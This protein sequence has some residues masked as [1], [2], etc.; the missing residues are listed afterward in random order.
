MA[1]DA[2][3]ADAVG[4]PLAMEGAQGEDT[5]GQTT[6]VD[7]VIPDVERNEGI[8]GKTLHD[9]DVGIS[10]GGK[11]EGA[12]VEREEYIR[13]CGGSIRGCGGARV[14]GCEITIVSFITFLVPPH[15]RTFVPP[16]SV[17]SITVPPIIRTH[18]RGLM[19]EEAEEVVDAL[20][21]GRQET[22]PEEALPQSYL[23]AD[24]ELADYLRKGPVALAAVE[25]IGSEAC[26]NV[27][28]RCEVRGTRYEITVV[29]FITI[30]VP[31]TT[32]LVPRVRGF[33]PVDGEGVEVVVAEVKHRV[34]LVHQSVA[35]PSLGILTDRVQRVPAT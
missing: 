34:E 35:Q 20:R 2:E 11:G 26:C 1:L 32:H 8:T 33:R 29:R 31:R 15:L 24:V 23:T 6:D 13:G 17:P 4:N 7:G 27:F 3:H 18:H 14:R 25:T 9:N 21:V 5:F 22:G 16:T 19:V 30:L 28:S 12:V 10:F